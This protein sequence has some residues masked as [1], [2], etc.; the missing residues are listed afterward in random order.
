MKETRVEKKRSVYEGPAMKRLLQERPAETAGFRSVSA[1]ID[2]VIDRYLE[3]VRR[4]M[5]VFSPEE[6]AVVFEGLRDAKTSES[7]GSIAGH[8]VV[9]VPDIAEVHGLDKIYG[10]DLRALERKLR[11]LNFA[12]TVAIADAAERFWS[13]G[14]NPR[15]EANEIVE[16]VTKVTA[17]AA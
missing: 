1:Q 8:V 15:G 11:A 3:I 5:P 17:K 7:A 14:V 12:Q 9:G 16:A 6:W 2:A 4:A 10:I 13:S